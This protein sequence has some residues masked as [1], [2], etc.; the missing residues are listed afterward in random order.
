VLRGVRCLIKGVEQPVV[1][2]VFVS[3]QQVGVLFGQN[4][5]KF[6]RSTDADNEPAA[7][8]PA[9]PPWLC[10]AVTAAGQ[11]MSSGAT[12]RV[13]LVSDGLLWITERAG[14]RYLRWCRAKRTAHE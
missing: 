14:L 11:L 13:G 5:S 8:R 3:G 4:R 12:R 1:Y 6:G 10:R 7:V 2:F 9:S